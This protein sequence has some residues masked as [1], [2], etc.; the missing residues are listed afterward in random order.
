[1]TAG[2]LNEPLSEVPKSRWLEGSQWHALTY[3]GSHWG[4]RDTR[5]SP[6]QWIKWASAVNSRGGV[7]TL[8]AGPN[9]DP[10]AGPIGSLASEQLLQLQSLKEASAHSPHTNSIWNLTTLF[11]TPKWSAY[12]R[13][14]SDGVK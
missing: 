14:K 8:D 12:D 3:L 10:K 13:P 4:A 11:H 5:F 7:V 2:E 6:E 9:Y 1:Y